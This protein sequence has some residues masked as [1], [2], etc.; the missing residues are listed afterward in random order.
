MRYSVIFIS[1][2]WASLWD[3]TQTDNEIQERH[4]FRKFLNTKMWRPAITIKRGGN[5]KPK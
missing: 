2:L 3:R 1:K 5:R 4:L